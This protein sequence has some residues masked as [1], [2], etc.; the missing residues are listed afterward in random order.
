MK[1]ADL[2]EFAEKLYLT[3]P[4]HEEF[5]KEILELIEIAEPYG[6]LVDELEHQCQ[7]APAVKTMTPLRM[8]E[9]LG[10]RDEILT[11]VEEKIGLYKSVFKDWG[12]S[13]RPQGNED[14]VIEDLFA[15]LYD[16]NAILTHSG[17]KERI[18]KS[19]VRKRIL[20]GGKEERTAA[21]PVE[22]YDL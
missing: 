4:R 8:A 16:L 7:N 18:L 14:D 12:I 22:F 13:E 3:A 1:P 5:A 21:A 10:D 20:S 17:H 15:T 2:R 11:S 19:L 6:E 9:Y